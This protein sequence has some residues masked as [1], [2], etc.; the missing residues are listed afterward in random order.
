MAD[1]LASVQTDPNETRMAK[2]DNS[3]V[4]TLLES[5]VQ[6]VGQCTRSES[7]SELSDWPTMRRMDLGLKLEA[8]M[9]LSSK[10]E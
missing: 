2:Q 9:E 8:K 10:S 4:R 7:K 5:I 3:L 6:G 1:P